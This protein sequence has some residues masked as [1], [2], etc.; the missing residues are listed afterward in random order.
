[1]LAVVVEEAQVARPQAA[2]AAAL[3]VLEQELIF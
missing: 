1:L 2:A 3:E